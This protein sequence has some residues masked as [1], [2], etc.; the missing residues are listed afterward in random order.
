MLGVPLLGQ[1]RQTGHRRTAVAP[2]GRCPSG[3]TARAIRAPTRW[4]SQSGW[5]RRTKSA[6]VTP[7]M[8]LPMHDD[9][10]DRP[11]VLGRARSPPAP[12]ARLRRQSHGHRRRL[13]SARSR[14]S[15][16]CRRTQPPQGVQLVLVRRP[17]GTTPRPARRPGPPRT[18][19]SGSRPRSVWPALS[20]TPAR[21]CPPRRPR[22][23]RRH[24]SGPRRTLARSCVLR[25]PCG[26]AGRRT[27]SVAAR[28][29]GE[30]ERRSVARSGRPTPASEPRTAALTGHRSHGTSGPV[31]VP[32]ARPARRP[33]TSRRR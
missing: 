27:G 1:Q 20:A 21:S 28:R 25:A 8:P 16:C 29:L 33:R 30:C 3:C 13:R 14:P 9:T 12:V 24:R 23:R 15:G 26:R 6:A 19:P 32:T 7:A 11:V 31:S 22:A 5:P 10:G 17:T 4:I 18:P 2:A